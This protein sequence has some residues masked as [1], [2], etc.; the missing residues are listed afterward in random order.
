MRYFLTTYCFTKYCFTTNITGCS[1]SKFSTA[2]GAIPI[3]FKQEQIVCS[4]NCKMI[5]QLHSDEMQ[6]SLGS[7]IDEFI[8]H[9]YACPE[10]NGNEQ[11]VIFST[12]NFYR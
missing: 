1:D 10:C 4:I 6:I 2:V 8:H 12:F 9:K 5:A 11:F 3:A 7:E